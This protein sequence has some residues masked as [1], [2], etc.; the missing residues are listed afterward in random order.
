MDTGCLVEIPVI[1]HDV[2]KIEK[3][4]ITKCRDIHLIA[5]IEEHIHQKGDVTKIDPIEK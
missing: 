3:R 2:E 4:M 1:A 5:D